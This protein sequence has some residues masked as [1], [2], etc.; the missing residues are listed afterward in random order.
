MGVF[1]KNVKENVPGLSFINQ[2]HAITYKIDVP[3]LRNFLGEDRQNEIITAEGKMVGEKN[4]EA[5]ALVEKGTREKEKIVHTGFAAQEVE[6]AA[7]R[8]G[9]DFSDVDK[10]ANE[11]TPYGLRYSEFVVPLVKAVQELSK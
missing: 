6:E 1:K 11:H 7:K 9:Y 4:P 2:L 8:I 5:E 10:P 3:T